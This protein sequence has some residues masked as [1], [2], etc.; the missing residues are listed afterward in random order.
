M[1]RD[2]KRSGLTEKGILEVIEI[3]NLLRK[4]R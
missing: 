3:G 4:G 2:R 1:R